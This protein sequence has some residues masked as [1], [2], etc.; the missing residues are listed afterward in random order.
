MFQVRGKA[1]A[2]EVGK[3]RARRPGCTVYVG[4]LGLGS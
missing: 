4:M 2:A 3:Q 1:W